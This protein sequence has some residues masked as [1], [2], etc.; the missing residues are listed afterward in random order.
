MNSTRK[1]VYPRYDELCK[2]IEYAGYIGTTFSPPACLKLL[3]EIESYA[4]QVQALKQRNEAIE[5]LLVEVVAHLRMQ[6]HF[7]KD[8]RQ[9]LIERAEKALSDKKT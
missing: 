3:E 5:P 6:A 4:Q 7:N 8:T 2:A 9:S 1:P